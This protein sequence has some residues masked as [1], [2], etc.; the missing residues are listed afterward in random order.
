[1]GGALGL[2]PVMRCDITVFESLA[3]GTNDVVN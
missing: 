1:M 2:C 3:S